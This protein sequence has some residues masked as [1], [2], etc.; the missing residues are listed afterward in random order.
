MSDRTIALYNSVPIMRAWMISLVSLVRQKEERKSSRV[1]FCFSNFSLIFLINYMNGYKLEGAETKVKWVKGCFWARTKF[2]LQLTQRIVFIVL[3][4]MVGT[5]WYPKQNIAESKGY[6]AF[7]K[8][9][10]TAKLA[11]SKLRNQGMK[12]VRLLFKEGQYCVK[13]S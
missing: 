6:I 11:A 9:I 7:F 2:D 1:Q 13:V 4:S 8:N 5:F 10:H 3:A 12:N